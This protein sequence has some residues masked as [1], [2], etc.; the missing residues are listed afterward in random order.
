[1]TV[2]VGLRVPDRQSG[3]IQ[4]YADQLDLALGR[5]GVE[6]R[7]TVPFHREV[8]VAGRRFL[9]STTLALD[10][11]LRI[12][13]DVTHATA[14][15]LNPW[16]VP[17]DVVTVHDV[18]NQA[19]PARSALGAAAL[20]QD[21]RFVLRALRGGHVITDSRHSR[22]EAVRLFPDDAQ[23]D[24]MTPIHLGV[25]PSVFHPDAGASPAPPQRTP[26]FAERRLNVVLFASVSL[27]K[28]VD[29]VLQAAL[30]APFVHLVHAGTT[31]SWAGHA[32]F[33][34]EVQA[35]AERLARQ[36]RYVRIARPDDHDVRR[37]L[38]QADLVVH[39]SLDEGFG[40]PPLEALACGARVL[41]SDIPPHREVLQ[42][43]AR[44]V[45][46]DATALL[47]AFQDAWDGSAVRDSWFPPLRR[48]LAHAATFTW[49]RTAKETL[50]VYERIDGSRARRRR[51]P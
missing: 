11:L 15:H 32:G 4:R 38:S 2:R 43:A 41:A 47:H 28:R 5:L 49:D 39:P 12:P 29:L 45:A 37:L 50:A 22:D 35:L 46:V 51:R 24:R 31:H 26:P 23:P 30:Q 10:P 18:M 19:N 13:G 48:R 34:R 8:R 3:G 21:R 36:G 17:A 20:R 33:L 7:R 42:D 16:R 14:Y 40:L 6:V 1:M 44:F 9:G 25:D 27:Q